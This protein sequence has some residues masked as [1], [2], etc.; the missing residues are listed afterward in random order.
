M[1]VPL[2]DWTKQASVVKRQNGICLWDFSLILWSSFIYWLYFIHNTL[3]LCY[4]SCPV[5]S[6]TLCPDSRFLPSSKNSP[7]PSILL[8]CRTEKRKL[9]MGHAVLGQCYQSWFRVVKEQEH[10]GICYGCQQGQQARGRRQG[11]EE[12]GKYN[13]RML[14]RRM[15]QEGWWSKCGSTNVMHIRKVN[16]ETVREHL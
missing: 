7:I 16:R 12:T 11:K 6:I 2:R 4:D 13:L 3:L 8:L 5:A 15:E 9:Q 10:P 1:L 14:N